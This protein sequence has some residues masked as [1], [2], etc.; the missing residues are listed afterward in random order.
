MTPCAEPSFGFH[1]R[2]VL[3]LSPEA[4]WA[5]SPRQ[6]TAVTS[7]ACPVSSRACFRSA[8]LMTRAPLPEAVT[9]SVP[10]GLVAIPRI[11]AGRPVMS[12]TGPLPGI[13]QSLRVLSWLP[14]RMCL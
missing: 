2:I 5:L 10:S 12:A 6:A 14:D 11:G 7:A 13:S 1:R 3:A 8:K 9:A 4:T